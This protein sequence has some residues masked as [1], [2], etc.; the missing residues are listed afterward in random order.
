MPGFGRSARRAR[1]VAKSWKEMNTRMEVMSVAMVAPPWYE[2][3]PSTYG[4]IEQVVA[5]LADGLV[6]RGH[7]VHLFGTGRDRTRAN[8]HQTYSEPPAP[9]SGGTLPELIQAAT[10]ARLLA[11][12]DHQVSAGRCD[13]VH[14]HS[15]AGPLLARGRDVP[16]V[17]TMH[18]PAVGDLARYFR[19]LGGTI[20]LVAISESQR[21]LAP[22]LPWIGTVYNGVDVDRFPYRTDKDDY[23]AFLGRYG[24]EKS[25]HL[26]IDAAREAGLPIRLAGKCTDPPELDYYATHIQPRAGSD[27][28]HL[29]QLGFAAKT[30]LLA[31]AR[32]LVFPSCWEEPFGLVMI[33]AMACGTPVVALDH[34]SVPEIVVD[35]VTGFVCKDPSDLPAAIRDAKRLDPAECRRH[36]KQ[37][38]DLGV[39]LAGYERLYR[40]VT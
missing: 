13:L 11:E 8:F 31:G 26:A 19:E 37:R 4:G 5:G 35:G 33:E 34:G 12:L 22:D 30:D 6:N 9:G 39:M 38:F 24:H 40:Q 20:G 2:I 10:T 25:P 29:G 16:T 3:P 21:R 14:D 36:V 32:C 7:R 1:T 18:W 28:E 23:V 27:A 17:V 15:L